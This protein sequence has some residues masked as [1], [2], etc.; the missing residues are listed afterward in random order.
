LRRD[1]VRER[2]LMSPPLLLL[3][4]VRERT[5]SFRPSRS[6]VNAPRPPSLSSR[7][8]VLARRDRRCCRSPARSRR[9]SGDAFRPGGRRPS[10]SGFCHG[11]QA[12]TDANVGMINTRATSDRTAK[13][14]ARVPT[15]PLLTTSPAPSRVPRR[16]APSGPVAPN[17]DRSA[18]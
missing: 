10:R 12:G 7:S 11:H 16:S 5:T 17:H 8:D 18:L 13:M 3:L 4:L 15:D 6:T 1:Q 9:C 2:C 14:A